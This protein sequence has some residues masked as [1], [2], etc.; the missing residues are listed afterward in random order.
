V[1]ITL[2]VSIE[3]EGSAAP[4]WFIIDP[5][6]NMEC[7]VS[8]AANQITGPFFS[9]EEAAKVLQNR[10]HHYSRRAVVFCGSACYTEQY[11]NA[12][13]NAEREAGK[14]RPQ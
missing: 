6:Q 14:R 4:W 1:E 5:T 3:N 7:N 13:R 9:R 8:M 10:S 2:D 12:Y 11:S